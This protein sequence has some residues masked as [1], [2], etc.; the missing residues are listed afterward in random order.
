FL[1]DAIVIEELAD[2]RAHALQTSLHSDICMPYL[3]HYGSEDQKRRF[4]R[5]AISGECLLAIA[6][7][8]PG[9]GSD[10]AAVQTK[11]IR[12]GDEYV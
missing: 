7:T 4:L 2:V 10:L 12:D 9:T 8:E 5:R 1:H 11:A 6:M 3:F